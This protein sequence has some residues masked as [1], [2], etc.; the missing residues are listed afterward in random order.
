MYR[1]YF[2]DRISAGL[3]LDGMPVAWH[4]RIT[5]SSILARFAPPAFK[6]DLTRTP[7]MAL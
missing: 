7:S 5:G 3:D 1:P 2:F 4:H 6:M